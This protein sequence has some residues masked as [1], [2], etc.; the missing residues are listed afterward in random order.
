[1]KNLVCNNFLNSADNGN[2][3]DDVTPL[4][5]ALNCNRERFQESEASNSSS[6]VNEVT[7]CD[8]DSNLQTIEGTDY[9]HNDLVEFLQNFDYDV[10]PLEDPSVL[11]ACESKYEKLDDSLHSQEDLSHPSAIDDFLKNFNYNL[12]TVDNHSSPTDLGNFIQN[13]D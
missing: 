6:G 9:N 7:D 5:S 11:V 12:E 13:F 4:L 3:T 8:S 1:M 2:C 10:E